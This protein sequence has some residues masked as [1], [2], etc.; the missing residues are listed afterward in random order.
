MASDIQAQI[1]TLRQQ[2]KE[3]RGKL[4]QNILSNISTDDPEL[5]ISLKQTKDL[6]GHFGKIY[7]MHWASDSKHLISASQDGKLIIWD[8][9]TTYKV[10]MINLRSS[11]VMTCAYAPS[12][13]MVACGGLDNLCSIYNVNLEDQSQ[14]VETNDLPTMEL[15][16]HDG[17]LSCCRFI[18]DSNIVT[19]SGDTTCI[20]WDIPTQTALRFFQDHEADVMSIAVKD[21]NVFVS[22]SCDSMAKVWDVRTNSNHPV[23]DF[24]GHDADIN[25][26]VWFPGQETFGTGSDD[27]SCRLFDLKAYQEL[28]SYTKPDIK[29]GVTSIDFSQ[30][31]KYLFC[32]Y[33]DSPFCAVWDTLK[34]TLIQELVPQGG[35]ETRV[36]CLG[37]PESGYC[38]GTGSWDNNLRIWAIDS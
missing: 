34:G 10:H 15:N 30:S 31:G 25:S 11:W 27:A 14:S 12:M 32:G 23:M 17:Y 28:N 36:S 22:G 7:S 29:C 2:I 35:R 13:N 6:Q 3:M 18:D 8:G 21:Q 37:V 1:S 26:V 20:L 9:Q 38:L 24:S 19:S 16:R 33:D 4:E 5:A